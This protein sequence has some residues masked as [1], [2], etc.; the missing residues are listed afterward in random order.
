MTPA[1]ANIILR[2]Q[3]DP[4][5]LP[6]LASRY[7]LDGPEGDSTYLTNGLGRVRL[8]ADRSGN[9]AENCLVLNGVTSNY[10]SSPDSAALSITGD[11]DIRVRLAMNDW[12][13]SASQMF[14][15]KDVGADSNR[16]WQFNVQAS[17]RPSFAWSPTGTGA[18]YIQV[19]CSEAVPAAD[20]EI[21]WVRVTLDVDDGSGNRVIRF[22][23]SEDGA[24]W[25][26]LG[27]TTT[28][29]GTASI[30]DTTAAVE[31]GSVSN[32]GAQPFAGRIYRV[33][34]R[35]GIDGTIVFDADF[36]KPAKLAA[37]FTEDSANG[38]T[39]TINTSG[40]T[41]A[42]I[43]GARDLYQGTTSKL[44][45]LSAGSD[46]RN[47]LTFDGSNDYMKAAPFSLSQPEMV[48][49]VGSQV[50][51][52]AGR[53]FFDGGD[54]DTGAVRQQNATPEIDLQGSGGLAAANTG[55]SVG[56]RCVLRAL[57]S[58]AA[59]SLHVNRASPTTGNT[60]TGAMNGFTLS[61]RADGTNSANITFS[62]VL[63]VTVAHPG[64]IQLKV[65]T[66]LM[67]KWN[68]SS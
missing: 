28:T 23:T 26:Q 14:V 2:G 13:P 17:G 58:G 6:N 42:R 15:A 46:G 8:I 59:S 68:V 47:L 37:S 21:K 44:A 34:I 3:L 24:T 20:F 49:F 33:Q 19:T 53:R 61:A 32:G 62:E 11:I 16:S 54:V 35:N 45:A 65:V 48:Y 40:D 30:A 4:Y 5:R 60:G 63:I 43:C 51:W 9:S 31:I 25:T 36:T 18:G 50:S 1:L 66:F 56:V 39:V 64:S 52:G 29:A 41:G 57:F 55:L 38:A 67:R 10:A 27:T 7:S 22:F 12:T